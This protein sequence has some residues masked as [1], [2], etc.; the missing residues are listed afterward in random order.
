MEKGFART[1]PALSFAMQEY[2]EYLL[3]VHPAPDVYALVMQEKQH[4]F[5]TYK[6][7]VAI[8]TKPFLV[9]EA[10]AIWSFMVGGH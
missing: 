4:F 6:E 3:V 7:K 2:Y 5:D 9:K 10:W 1:A 8:K